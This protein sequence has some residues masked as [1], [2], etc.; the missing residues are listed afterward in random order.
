VAALVEGAAVVTR[1]RVAIAAAVAVAA[2]VAAVLLVALG[3]RASSVTAPPHGI[4]VATTVTPRAALFG[5]PIVARL[6]V[7]LDPHDIDAKSLNLD[8][9]YGLYAPS[10]PTQVTRSHVGRLTRVVYATRLECL[11]LTC[12]SGSRRYVTLPSAR[13]TFTRADGSADSRSVDW[14]PVEVSSRLSPA[15]LE[16]L[17]PI[18]QPP[19]HASTALPSVTYRIAPPLLVVLLAIVGVAL[20]VAAGVVAV[21]VLSLRM[22]VRVAASPPA[23]VEVLRTLTPLERAL[24]MLERARE[25]GAVPEQRKA[26][27]NLAGE[28][29]RSGERELARS[30]TLLA[31]AER[32]PGTDATGALAA[33]VQQRIAKG[34]NGRAAEA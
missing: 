13:L 8:A 18:D 3:G 32:P 15:D 24:H 11:T 5:D 30:A 7:L 2:A 1:A 26:L 6:D 10:A 21:R 25:R 22:P 9:R 12:Y 4:G 14:F 23:P 16:L 29:R 20:L 19:F 17:S 34:V 33:A 28:L 31:W 27:E